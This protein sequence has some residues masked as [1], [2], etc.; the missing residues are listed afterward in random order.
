[1]Y[2][3]LSTETFL[4]LKRTFKLIITFHSVNS[5]SDHH[6]FFLQQSFEHTVQS[7]DYNQAIVIFF[8]TMPYFSH[9]FS[10]PIF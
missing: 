10:I 1:M 6:F 2:R 7:F 8:N 3:E 4:N 9:Q 5:I